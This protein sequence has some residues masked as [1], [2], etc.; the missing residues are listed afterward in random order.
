MGFRQPA[1]GV[2]AWRLALARI[3]RE[4]IRMP[5]HQA[6]GARLEQLSPGALAD[7]SATIRAVGLSGVSGAGGRS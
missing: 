5:A 7:R 2:S 4:F 6:M 1:D 3:N